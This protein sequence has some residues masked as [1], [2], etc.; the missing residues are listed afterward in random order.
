M[1][2]GIGLL[3][4]LLAAGYV[5][6]EMRHAQRDALNRQAI[7]NVVSGQERPWSDVGERPPPA[8][9]SS[10]RQRWNATRGDP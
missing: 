1:K 8:D 10:V 4:A 2:R 6:Y 7:E 5:L 9:D 3:L